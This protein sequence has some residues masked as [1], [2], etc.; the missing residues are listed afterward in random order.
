MIV[1]EVVVRVLDVILI[2]VVIPRDGWGAASPRLPSS[3]P[4]NPA[5]LAR[6]LARTEEPAPEPVNAIGLPWDSSY[7]W[8]PESNGKSIVH[9]L[10]PDL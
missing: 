2:V 1:I 6:N 10:Q 7:T 3:K 8:P 9:R 5:P 4:P